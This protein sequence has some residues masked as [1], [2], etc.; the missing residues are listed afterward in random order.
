[1]TR[2]QWTE[3]WRIRGV[4]DI[5]GNFKR[6]QWMRVYVDGGG[7]NKWHQKGPVVP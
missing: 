4:Y 7:F 5:F 1:M 2:P 3:P 6:R